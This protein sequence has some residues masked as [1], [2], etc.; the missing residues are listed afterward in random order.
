MYRLYFTVLTL[1]F[2]IVFIPSV[3][4]GVIR[5]DINND[6]VLSLHDAILGMS[7]LCAT[8][9]IYYICVEDLYGDKGFYS[10]M[11]S[12]QGLTGTSSANVEE[13]D[14]YEPDDN[15]QDATILL[16]DQVQ[17]HSFSKNDRDWFRFKTPQ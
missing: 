10:V 1:L 8:G 4:L 2:A 17:D 6:T 16:F 15:F 14:S 5:G 7:V 13:P 3:T 9:K 11:I 12:K